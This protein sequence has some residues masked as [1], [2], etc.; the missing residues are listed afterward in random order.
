MACVNC[1]VQTE[2]GV[3]ICNKCKSDLQSHDHIGAGI[4]FSHS[5]L[6]YISQGES[7]ILDIETPLMSDSL[8]LNTPLSQEK[9]LI[10]EMAFP[11]E[12]LN[13]E[14]AV[15]MQTDIVR[16]F[17]SLGLPLDIEETPPTILSDNELFLAEKVIL[18]TSELEKR[19]PDL[20]D[21]NL[22]LFAGSFYYSIS[23]A[24][25]GI[26]TPL[27]RKYHLEKAEEYYDKALCIDPDSIFAW[28]NKAK[29]LLEKGDNSEAIT[30]LDWILNNLKLPEGDNS[31]LLNK[32]IAFLHEGKLEE[33]RTCF[34]GVIDKDPA[35][36]SAWYKNGQVFDKM[37]RWGG[38]I[39]CYT[40]ALKHDPGRDDI[41]LSMGETYIN[42]EKYQDASRC[43]DEAL[44]IN[45][46]NAE[47][48]YLQGMV[49]S[50]IGRWGAA[51]Q[52]LDK[53]LSLN[54]SH[55]LALK[56]KG[57]VLM[58]TSRYDDA[59]KCL[60]KALR[61]QPNNH[62]VLGSIGRLLKLTNRY[63]EALSIIES[64]LALKR[65]DA[66]ALYEKG[67]ILQETG[68]AYKA[69]KCFDYSLKIDPKMV[70]AYYKKGLTLEKLRR[71]KEAIQ[72]YDKALELDPKFKLAEKAK[73]D[74]TLRMK[75][76][77]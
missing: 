68:K 27:D 31:V 9:R 61:F 36:V 14:N 58:G 7:A 55:V 8:N 46:W 25:C 72:C 69:L 75:G 37:G 51:V 77:S 19:F 26:A 1:G 28:K 2:P 34:D 48:W 60:E 15:A 29:V 40:E 38:T 56:V 54:S 21:L 43:L 16:I 33:A 62:D 4:V 67:D 39:Q 53:A 22:F 18:A 11:L 17:E 52:C 50:K 65:D 47:A 32:G 13:E 42:H 35:S 45:I 74:C 3:Y 64:A 12:N 23:T 49:F 6:C 5:P 44:R 59:L 41:W 10:E 30:L 73:S 63:D 24:F 76:K 70:K 66:R 71:Y 57:E 20:L